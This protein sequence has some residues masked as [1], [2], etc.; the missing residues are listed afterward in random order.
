MG[1]A[2]GLGIDPATAATGLAPG[3]AVAGAISG[4][5]V[6]GFGPGGAAIAGPPGSI[7]AYSLQGIYFKREWFESPADCLTAAYAKRLPLEVCQ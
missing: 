1:S 6:G 7:D 3:G 5:P 2:V 4:G